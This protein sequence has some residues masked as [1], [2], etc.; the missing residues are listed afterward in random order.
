MMHVKSAKS[1]NRLAK[2]STA[3]ISN[4]H[5]PVGYGAEQTLTNL[6]YRFGPNYSIVK[7]VLT[8]VQSLMGGKPKP[9]PSSMSM[10]G[11]EDDDNNKASSFKPRRVLDFGCGV[12]SSGA[13]ALDVFGV[14]RQNSSSSDANNNTHGGDKNTSHDGIEW[15]H[16]V[17]ASQSMRETT[18]HILQS[19]LQSSPWD[20][21]DTTNDDSSDASMED[22]LLEEEMAQYEQL[23]DDIRGTS[24]G[25]RGGGNSKAKLEERQRKRMEKWEHTWI[26]DA[27]ARTRLTFGESI[28][29][30]SSFYSDGMKS[31]E[32]DSRPALPWQAKLDEQ[33]RQAREKKK[34]D[35]QQQSS[36]SSN[37]KKQGSFDLILCSYTLSEL[38]SVPSS[39]AAATLL[40]EKLANNG[41]LVF[42]EPG[43]PDG[44][45]LLRS[46]RSML[47]ECCPP[48]E[49]MEKRR[50]R[51]E[52]AASAT[53]MEEEKATVEN[54][55]SN[56]SESSIDIEEA[57]TSPVDD[58]VWHEECH[59]IAPCTHNGTCPMSRHQ[60]DHVKG[61]T[62]F[63]RY[64][65]AAEPN[66]DVDSE[67]EIELRNEEHAGEDNKDKDDGDDIRDVL[68]NWDNMS[69]SDKDE[70][71]TMFGGE[72]MSDDEVK[73]M[74][75]YMDSEDLDSDEEEDLDSDSDHDDDEQEY[76]NIDQETASD[77]SSSKKA[78]TMAKTDVFDTSFCSFVHKFPGG[79]SLSK[80]EK[81]TYLVLQKRVP[82]SNDNVI[83]GVLNS[84]EEVSLDDI[85]VVEMMSKSVHHGQ[86][87]KKEELRMRL[88][89]KRSNI[90]NGNDTTQDP[91]VGSY[92][93]DQANEV[94]Q[95]AVDVEDAFLDS[96]VDSLGLE[97][98]TGDNR[99]KGWGRLIRAPL[100]RKG[101]V[102]IDYCSAGCGGGCSDDNDWF[103][104][105]PDGTQGRIIRQKVS[106]G[107]SARSAP[108]CYSAARRA[109]WGGLWPDLVERVKRQ[110]EKERKREMNRSSS[111]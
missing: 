97:M 105:R 77:D 101:H 56:G 86:Q 57:I 110:D 100:K 8:E 20:E 99:R 35:V 82:S 19:I 66:E 63:G 29:D 5:R 95:R 64:E 40:W 71:K 50:K 111:S 79:S 80:G 36:S 107:W 15:I 109:R 53:I 28:V 14:S 90:N 102:L 92:H 87:L 33:R 10:I 38:P 13:A 70:L 42:V 108:G 24:R 65:A 39:L 72:D 73:S 31:D 30:T 41:V 68:D 3:T 104:E 27:D 74:L 106:R 45:G 21:K 58:D 93:Q 69:E 23:I 43:T 91:E 96:N 81:F 32:D 89:Q 34:E 75:E 12:G 16:S 62:R 85:D 6:R 78:S 88:Q 9:S 26:K 54:D 37:Q 52:A 17:D 67:E 76:Y 11:M 59:V 44:F 46:V 22:K 4:E 18:D 84:E 98:L 51:K 1:A 94:L 2:S 49:L 48:P 61:N 60:R 25:G 55:D 103:E 47:L 83:D 7:R